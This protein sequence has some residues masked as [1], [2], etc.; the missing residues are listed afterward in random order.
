MMNRLSIGILSQL[1]PI[2]KLHHFNASCSVNVKSITQNGGF[3]DG[4]LLT[5]EFYCPYHAAVAHF[6]LKT[7]EKGGVPLLNRAAVR[8]IVAVICDPD[9]PN[10]GISTVVQR[11]C[12]LPGER[13]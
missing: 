4:F 2:V 13:C 1:P 9:C 7:L 6:F 10:G 8:R 11:Q 3:G 5:K 12:S